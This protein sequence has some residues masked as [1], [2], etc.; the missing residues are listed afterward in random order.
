MCTHYESLSI[1]LS[2]TVCP[3][4]PHLTILLPSTLAYQYS[5]VVQDPSDCDIASA[6]VHRKDFISLLERALDT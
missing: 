3:R 2:A 4:P 1:L 5:G 6:K